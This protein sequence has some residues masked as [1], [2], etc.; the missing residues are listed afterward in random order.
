MSAVP[1]VERAAA[2]VVTPVSHMQ[3][4]DAYELPDSS[5]SELTERERTIWVNAV[6][7]GF[8]STYG[9]PLLAGRDVA[10]TDR[11]GSPEVVVVNQAFARKYTNGQ[12]PLGHVVREIDRPE[13]EAPLVHDR[14]RGRGCGL[15]RAP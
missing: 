2:S 14:G 7:P 11:A 9:I 6:T 12:S 1:G 4:N 10:A 8:F 3:W 5:G 13:H 15:R